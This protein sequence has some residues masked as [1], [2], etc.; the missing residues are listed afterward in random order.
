VQDNDSGARGGFE[1]DLIWKDGKF[2][3]TVVR[4]TAGKSTVQILC[5]SKTVNLTLNA[6]ALQTIVAS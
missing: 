2:A 3:G 6:R 1:G 5:A 4:N